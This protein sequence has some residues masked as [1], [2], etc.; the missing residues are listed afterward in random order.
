MF[1][2][3]I[4]NWLYLYVSLLLENSQI[5]FPPNI[6]YYYLDIDA[7]KQFIPVN[8]KKNC[9]FTILSDLKLG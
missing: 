6:E 5:L 3:Y 9:V 1:L 8:S 4:T 7:G 2:L